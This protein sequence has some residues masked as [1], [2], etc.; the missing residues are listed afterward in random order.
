MNFFD[1]RPLSLILCILLGAFV[2]FS[3]SG[4]VSKIIVFSLA[5]ILIL[6]SF[7][8]LHFFREKR[9]W[10]FLSSSLIII[11]S[12]LS[13]LYFNLWFYADN[14]YEDR[15]KIEGTVESV[16]F[17]N[18]IKT[19]VLKADSVNGDAFSSYKFRVTL[20]DENVINLSPATKISFTA[21]LDPFYDTADFDEAA[22]YYSKGYNAQAVEVQD[23]TILSLEK[24]TLSYRINEYRKALTRKLVLNSSSENGGLL[25][26]LLLGDREF[27]PGQTRLDFSRI[28]ITHILALSG[29]HLSILCYGLSRILSLIGINKKIRKA[30][31]IL[32]AV[33]Y[34]SLTGFPVSVV[35]AGVMLVISS[36]LFL[37]SS[38]KDSATNLCL[39]VLIIIL[40]EPYSVFDI[41]LWLSAFATLGIVV[42]AELFEGREPKDRTFFIKVLYSL[43]VSFVS[44]VFAISATVLLTHFKFGTISTLSLFTTVLFSPIILAFMYVGMLFLLTSSFFKIGSFINVFGDFIRSLAHFF[45][46]Y[47]Y[48]LLSTDF[49]VTEIFIIAAT[50]LF[51]LFIVIKISK[52]KTAILLLVSLLLSSF[53]SSGIHTTVQNEESQFSYNEENSRERILLKSNY[54]ISLIEI[55]SLTSKI[56]R[57]TVT[58]LRSNAIMHLD[59][60]ILTAYN[61][62]SIS[63]LESLLSSILI[64]KLYLPA[65]KTEYQKEIYT[66]LLSF[67]RAYDIELE[68]YQ[69]NIM[70]TFTNFTLFP[71]YFDYKERLAFTVLYNNEFYTYLTAD[72]LDADTVNHALNIMNGACTVIVGAKGDSLDLPEFIYKLGD[73]TRLI[74]NKKTGLTDEILKYYENRI[75]VDP[76]GSI[77][78]YVE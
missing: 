58:Y 35:R 6:V 27:L 54:E 31:E 15:C 75:T 33:L 26:A 42:C 50:A 29:M 39:A 53:I 13:Y 32:F 43:F 78:L 22:Y 69:E 70:L 52:R 74:Y 45:S 8:D 67:K 37:L 3:L 44:T 38:S 17:D 48:A 14:R 60:Y 2:F 46:G 4:N 30:S 47:K 7:F 41:S 63:T 18:S 25:A 28:G 23:F 20:E 9:K 65:P 19:I 61:Q 64:K 49:I 55:S 72:M 16:N 40:I 5:I 10:L 77:D 66:E 1:K 34:M 12:L 21:K 11:A 57:E 24:T 62:T 68:I 36:A 59:N 51:F 73:G 56:G 76:N 71:V